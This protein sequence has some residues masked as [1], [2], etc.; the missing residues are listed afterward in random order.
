[1][2]VRVAVPLAAVVLL[3][4]AWAATARA[5]DAGVT[6][7]SQ[8]AAIEEAQAKKATALRNFKPDK[9]EAIATALENSLIKR[10]DRLHP[11][12]ESAYAGGGFTVGAGY[13]THVSA[14]DIP[15]SARQHYI[16]RL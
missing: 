8:G 5:Q 13:A 6:P 7:S 12:F 3:S 16:V 2:I 10:L 15:K 11:F 9:A 14:Y 1:M 4:C